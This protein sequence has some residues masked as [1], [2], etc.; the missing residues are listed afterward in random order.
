MVILVACRRGGAEAEVVCEGGLGWVVGSG[1]VAVA[2]GSSSG[3]LVSDW[4][5]VRLAC[6]PACLLACWLENPLV[7]VK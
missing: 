1:T 3:G 4:T 2:V 5:E 7:R 6:L